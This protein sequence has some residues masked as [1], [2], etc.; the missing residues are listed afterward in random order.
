MRMILRQP[1][2]LNLDMELL[3]S[4]ILD[5][6]ENQVSYSLSDNVLYEEFIVKL[7]LYWWSEELW[8]NSI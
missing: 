8:R 4:S 7:D 6:M 2:H 5:Q 3:N 1:H